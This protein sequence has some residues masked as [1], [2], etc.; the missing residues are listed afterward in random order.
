MKRKANTYPNK[1]CG[2]V[3][4]VYK[5]T[6]TGLIKQI[7]ARNKELNVQY[8]TFGLKKKRERK[9]GKKTTRTA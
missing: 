1:C 6:F 3:K 5:G 9:G 2:L 4:Y 7:R 8:G